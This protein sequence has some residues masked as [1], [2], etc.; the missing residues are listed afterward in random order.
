MPQQRVND[1]GGS[2]YAGE[3]PVSDGTEVLPERQ[4][5]SIVDVDGG[6]QQD[7]G[8]LAKSPTNEAMFE[9]IA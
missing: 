9:M 6:Q 4:I 8:R 3:Q 5:L 1:D 7:V 2:D